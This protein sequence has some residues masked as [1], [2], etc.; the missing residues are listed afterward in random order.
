MNYLIKKAQRHDNE[1]FIELME[2]HKICMYKVARSYLCQ[3]EDIAD[4]MQETILTCYEKIPQLKQTRFFKT[5]LLR[6]LINKCNDVLR[7]KQHECLPGE[8]PDKG[9]ECVELQ[10]YEFEELLNSLDEKYRIILVLYYS[11]GFKVR[12]IAQILDMQENTVKT[13][14]VRA[15]R[16]FEQVYQLESSVE[17]RQTHGEQVFR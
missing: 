14:L 10:N 17:R 11:E 2:L 3:E 7:E 16:Q 4:V 5:W 12:E 8:L 1:A 15:R 9:D 13:R 6:I